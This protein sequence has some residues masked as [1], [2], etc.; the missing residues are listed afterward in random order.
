[1]SASGGA[2][3]WSSKGGERVLLQP[4]RLNNLASSL[5]SEARRNPKGLGTVSGDWHPSL[6]PQ[7][8]EQGHRAG[9]VVA[10]EVDLI[11]NRLIGTEPQ[12]HSVL[13]LLLQGEKTESL[14]PLL[15]GRGHADFRDERA[16]FA[17]AFDL[18][19]SLYR[20]APNDPA[21]SDLRESLRDRELG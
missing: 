3:D 10:A 1:V 16:Y 18:I 15:H 21:V 8:R 6:P 5:V 4:E 12:K 17:T 19:L 14:P 20:L 7:V 13:P 9:Y 2:E 11:H